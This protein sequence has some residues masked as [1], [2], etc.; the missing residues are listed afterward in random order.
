MHGQ[1]D[2]GEH[3]LGGCPL[4]EPVVQMLHLDPQVAPA[5]IG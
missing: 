5:V 3:L 4:A 1:V 2:V